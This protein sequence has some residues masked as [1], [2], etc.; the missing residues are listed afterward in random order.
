MPLPDERP[1]Q[2]VAN[3]IGRFEQQ[4]NRNPVSNTSSATPPSIVIPGKRIGVEERKASIGPE[5][6]AGL[7]KARAASEPTALSDPVSVLA[8][9]IHRDPSGPPP[10]YEKATVPVLI[11]E[12]LEMPPV[13]ATNEI[14]Q[15]ITPPEPEPETPIPIKVAPDPLPSV[16]S[17]KPT[18]PGGTS[19]RAVRAS[20]IPATTR[21]AK[22]T[23]HAGLPRHPSTPNTVSHL[24]HL[25]NTDS[26][27][28][29]GHGSKASSADSKPPP[30]TSTLRT[31]TP[32]PQARASVS[33][34]RSALTAP[35][36]SSLAKA[37][38]PVTAAASKSPSG[39]STVKKASTL[40][41]STTSD[42]RR[43][44]AKTPPP[45]ATT[46]AVPFPSVRKPKSKVPVA[47]TAPSSARRPRVSLPGGGVSAAA[48][49]ARAAVAA[50]PIPT[51]PAELVPAISTPTPPTA[52]PATTT[53]AE[54]PDSHAS[55]DLAPDVSESATAD[56]T[57]RGMKL[58]QC[59]N[60]EHPSPPSKGSTSEIDAVGNEAGGNSHDNT[61]APEP[62]C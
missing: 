1:R 20:A 41:S 36:A 47:S 7:L 50:P 22:N 48:L 53:E 16:V 6:G 21:A 33:G 34:T 49:A 62:A 43:T 58:L 23:Q 11:E 25:C 52:S 2:S 5:I 27:P 46:S 54:I 61:R 37:R 35:T 4:K 45:P 9:N 30:S 55:P 40:A 12:P 19:T 17:P 24:P 59:S 51:L 44:P 38:Q 14:P 15:V 42:G 28:E 8:E 26:C 32:V 18:P 60:W 31:K 29:H 3:L 13:P 56:G 10:P 39:S 57:T